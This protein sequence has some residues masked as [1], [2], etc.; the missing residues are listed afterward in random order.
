MQIHVGDVL[1]EV[2]DECVSVMPAKQGEKWNF[3]NIFTLV[4]H[5]ELFSSQEILHSCLF[6]VIKEN[7]LLFI[8]L[9]MNVINLIKLI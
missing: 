7:L 6:T 3:G 1:V 8:I 4:K 9:N 2:N 5:Y